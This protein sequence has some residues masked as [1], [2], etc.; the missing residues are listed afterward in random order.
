MNYQDER[1]NLLLI[2]ATYLIQAL[3]QHEDHHIKFTLSGKLTFI[4][5]LMGDTCSGT[6]VLTFI[7]RYSDS[8]S[9]RLLSM[10]IL[11]RVQ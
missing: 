1:L 4:V 6:S 7:V 3:E 5:I 2:Q 9:R 8:C 11:L 10:P